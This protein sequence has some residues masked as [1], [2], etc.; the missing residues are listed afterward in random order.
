MAD[1]LFSFSIIDNDERKT[2]GGKALDIILS[3]RKYGIK[4]SIT[5]LYLMKKGD[6]KWADVV[7]IL[8]EQ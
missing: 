4:I 1:R 3:L 7:Q 8:C 5:T 2:Y 6:K